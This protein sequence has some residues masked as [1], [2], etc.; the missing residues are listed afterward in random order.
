MMYAVGSIIKYKARSLTFD[1]FMYYKVIEYVMFTEEDLP[2]QFKYLL[3][4]C[5]RYL[6]RFSKF[7][8]KIV[9]SK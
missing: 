6:N 5:N 7:K 3:K 8:K 9:I 1:A 2:K 4:T